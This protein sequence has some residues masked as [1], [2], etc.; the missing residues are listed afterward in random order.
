MA[1]SKTIT[2]SSTKKSPSKKS[3]TTTTSSTPKPSSDFITL[4][5]KS[6][7]PKDA[8]E[9][10]KKEGNMKNKGSRKGK[11]AWV[12]NIDLTV[13]EESLEQQ[14]VEERLGGKLHER[15]NDALFTIDKAGDAKVRQ[16]LKHK[17]LRVDE[18]LQPQS[19]INSPIDQT[20]KKKTTVTIE[21]EVPGGKRKFVSKAV[22]TKVEEMAKRRLA[23]HPNDVGAGKKRKS[24]EGMKDMWG[25]EE[26]EEVTPETEYL[27]HT[28]VRAVKKPKLPKELPAH[29]PAVRVAAPGAS[30]NPTFDDHQELLGK[31][32][33]VEIKKE[34]EKERFQKQMSYPPELDDLDDETY[35]DSDE[36]EEEE[37]VAEDTP[38]KKAAEMKR[39]TKAERKKE[40]KKKK[41]A[42]EEERK[43][44]EKDLLQQLSKLPE[45]SQAVETQLAKKKN[46]ADNK[47]KPKRIGPILF[48]PKPLEIKLTEEITQG[49]RKLKARNIL[50]DRFTSLQERSI[51][52][53]RVARGRRLRYK[54]K[55]T[56]NHDYKRFDLETL[57]KFKK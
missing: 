55:E 2:P 48:K 11:K 44:Q 31:A 41:L 54:R 49:L 29:V 37:T 20:G 24:V 26:K 50:Q 40:E 7:V 16:S 56:E 45:I 46:V 38:E 32:L 53:T 14:R 13:V 52:E 27:E 57:K 4:D 34:S 5:L 8:L 35:F 12:K 30:Y 9:T 47:D 19:A 51:I 25:V 43:R 3:I 22:K 18:I 15:A 1:P 21:P 42:L 23:I 28:Q 33:D 36:E 17:R 10:T 6:K 39:K